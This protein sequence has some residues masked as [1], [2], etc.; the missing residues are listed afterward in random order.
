MKRGATT[1][2]GHL[3]L[4]HGKYQGKNTSF[5]Y[6]PPYRLHYVDRIEK[7]EYDSSRKEWV[8]KVEYKHYDRSG[9]VLDFPPYAKG[10]HICRSFEKRS[11]GG[12]HTNPPSSSSISF[13]IVAAKTPWF[14]P[15]S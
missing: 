1:K 7:Q 5:E 4:L 9:I 3:R 15:G 14:C 11:M 10:V 6:R 8:T 13:S 12:R 2:G